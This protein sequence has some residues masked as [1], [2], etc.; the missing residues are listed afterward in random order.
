M[1]RLAGVAALTDAPVSAPESPVVAVARHSRSVRVTHWV[2]A[3]SFIAL[4]ISGFVILMS[5]PRLYWGEAGNDLTPAL[6]ELPISR[7]YKHG[8]WDK[9]VAFSTAP[10]SPVSASR[11]YDIFNENGWGR[12]L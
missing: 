4:A 1:A 9:P 3:A 11:T 7:N 10:G 2:V 12:S 8:G 6:I 5:H